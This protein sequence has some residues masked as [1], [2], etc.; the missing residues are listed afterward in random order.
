M[1]TILRFGNHHSSS[2]TVE[3]SF[4]SYNSLA[5][6]FCSPDRA[7]CGHSSVDATLIINFEPVFWIKTK[8]FSFNYAT[9]CVQ[10]RVGACIN[11]S[12]SS[13]SFPFFCECSRELPRFLNSAYVSEQ[14]S[15]A[16]RRFVFYKEFHI[17]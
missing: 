4:K 15:S 3:S 10:H 13:C 14:L 2:K 1:R 17:Y 11:D 16:L 5:R 7:I 12:V 8:I 9:F 6:F